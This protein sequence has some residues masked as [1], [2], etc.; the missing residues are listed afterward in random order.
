MERE[1]LYHLLEYPSIYSLSQNLL[2]VGEG[3][4]LKKLYRDIFGPS[5][6]L[7]LDVGCGPALLTLPPDGIVIGVDINP[8]YVKKYVSPNGEGAFCNVG[9][10]PRKKSKC[11]GVVSTAGLLPFGSNVFD[12]VRSDGLLHH[13]PEETA[14]EAVKE[15]LRC[16]RPAGRVIIIDT[17]WPRYPLL[18]PV[19]WLLRKLDRGRWTRTEDELLKIAF[20]A[21]T[22]NWT[23]KRCTYSLLGLELLLLI[24]E[25]PSAGS[26]EYGIA[27]VFDKRIQGN[28]A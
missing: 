20:L 26:L 27:T 25:K 15:M 9:N 21:D 24:Y 5:Q 2:S 17:A 6:G 10:I 14:I 11:L 13:L 1:K 4:F 23:L 22:R 16:T 8:L 19:A 18:R 28:R 12:E 7:V 3:L